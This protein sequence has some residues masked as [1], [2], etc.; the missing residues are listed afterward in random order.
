MAHVEYEPFC[1]DYYSTSVL[2]LPRFFA[3]SRSYSEINLF[4][5]SII[6]INFNNREGLS[7]TFQ[8]IRKIKNDQIEYI[9]IDAM[10]SD[11]SGELIKENEEWIDLSVVESDKGIYDGMNKGIALASGQYCIFINSGDLLVDTEILQH[12]EKT[13]AMDIVYGNTL[14]HYDSGFERIAKAVPVSEIWKSLPFIHQSV[15]VKTDILKQE[16]FDLN[17]KFCS[18]YES[19]CRLESKKYSFKQIDYTIAQIEAGGLSDEK[20]DEATAE[21]FEISKKYRNLSEEQIKWFKKEIR[22]GKKVQ[23]IKK[24]VPKSLIKFALKM[25]YRK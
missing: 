15:W 9:V 13:K 16:L 8:S 2:A 7:K 14:V 25:K 19:F 5:L 4:Q 1:L 23:A 3:N 6:T 17:Y 20:R 24:W 10:S 11:G 21:V 12:I 22:K 18:D